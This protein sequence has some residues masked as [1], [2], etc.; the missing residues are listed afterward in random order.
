[1]DTRSS[2]PL[3]SILNPREDGQPS[4]PNISNVT[5]ELPQRTRAKPCI[6]HGG[7]S[8]ASTSGNDNF[9]TG[10]VDAG[11]NGRTGAG[12]AMVSQLPCVQEPQGRAKSMNLATNDWIY[13]SN[14][15][16][17][18][19]R[20]HTQAIRE[21]CKIMRQLPEQITKAWN[22][23]HMP[24]RPQSFTSSRRTRST[25]WPC[26]QSSSPAVSHQQDIDI[27]WY[28]AFTGKLRSQNSSC[29]I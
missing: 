24:P 8:S 9:G 22:P 23:A 11:S 3:A 29:L 13:G 1:M 7:G 27:G 18:K 2:I 25:A 6:Q 20:I 19:R 26:D 15:Q 14:S 10:S 12:N 4:L 21:R 28:G 5:M 16:A 17:G